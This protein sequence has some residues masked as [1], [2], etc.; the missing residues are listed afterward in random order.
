MAGMRNRTGA[1]AMGAALLAGD[2]DSTVMR[3]ADPRP[4]CG[5]VKLSG[6]HL[7]ARWPC[8]FGKAS[9]LTSD[10]H[11]MAPPVVLTLTHEP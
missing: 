5:S 3:Q 8:R 11:V 4:R 2:G 1:R 10:S 6:A 7:P 9:D